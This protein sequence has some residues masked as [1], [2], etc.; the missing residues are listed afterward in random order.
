T[1]V[2]P[3]VSIVVPCYNYGHYLADCFRSI[4]GQEG[5][6]DLEVIAVDDASPDNTS[7][8]LREWK[9]PRLRVI[10][11]ATNQ[12]HAAAVTNGLVA[13]R[14]KYVARIDPDDR[15]RP[16]F[17]STLVPVLEADPK[18]GMAYGNAALID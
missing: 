16:S 3:L 7:E 17:L 13:A 2:P 9:D 12:G 6:Y 18:I 1:R 15:Y 5:D 10:T 8:I 11:H 14:G 4:F